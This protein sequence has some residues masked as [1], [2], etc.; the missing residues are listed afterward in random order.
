MPAPSSDFSL[1]GQWALVTGASRG[2]GREV[3]L[4]LARHGADVILTGRK[5]TEAPADLDAVA[6]TIRSLGRRAECVYADLAD[7]A[8]V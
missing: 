8:A 7:V 5:K 1:A 3:A 2:I 4:H 6:E